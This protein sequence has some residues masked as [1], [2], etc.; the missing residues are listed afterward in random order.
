M[1]GKRYEVFKCSVGP[2]NL[3]EALDEVAATG[4]DIVSVVPDLRDGALGFVSEKI[5]Y[6]YL[7]VAAYTGPETEEE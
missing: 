4:G 3:K 1:A 6:G 7:I 2:E 5:I